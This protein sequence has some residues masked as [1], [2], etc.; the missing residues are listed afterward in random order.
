MILPRKIS[1]HGNIQKEK[2]VLCYGCKTRHML[3]ENFSE[4]TLAPEGSGMSFIEQSGTP[5]KDLARVEPEF[6][7]RDLP[8]WK[9]SVELLSSCGG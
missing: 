6:F 8:F 9:I 1:F 5:R 2:V 3:G 4:A 7:C